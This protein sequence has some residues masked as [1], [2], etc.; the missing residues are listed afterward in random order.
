MRRG[1]GRGVRHKQV[2]TRLDSEEG[3]KTPARVRNAGSL[4]YS[5]ELVTTS[6]TYEQEL[7]HTALALWFAGSLRFPY[8]AR[9]LTYFTGTTF[10]ANV[11]LT[12][13]GAKELL[14][15]GAFVVVVVDLF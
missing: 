6:R 7:A 9:Y 5:S 11:D 13:P 2:C 3:Q 4:D 14:K 10:L 8:C 1:R 12:H 15:R